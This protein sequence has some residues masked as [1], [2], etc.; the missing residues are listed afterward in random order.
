MAEFHDSPGRRGTEGYVEAQSSDPGRRTYVPLHLT[1]SMTLEKRV[2]E[3]VQMEAPWTLEMTHHRLLAGVDQEIRIAIYQDIA[4]LKALERLFW[5]LPLGEALLIFEPSHHVPQF[6]MKASLFPSFLQHAR[7]LRSWLHDNHLTPDTRLRFSSEVDAM[8]LMDHPELEGFYHMM[9]ELNRWEWAL[10][11]V[12]NLFQD[13]DSTILYSWFPEWQSMGVLI[14]P[15]RFT[16][17]PRQ[18]PETT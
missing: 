5:D 16:P 1:D 4:G 10:V 11:D 17:P 6:R 15:A 2:Q 7:R 18:S 3:T 9:R 12:L 8:V 14:H 13:L